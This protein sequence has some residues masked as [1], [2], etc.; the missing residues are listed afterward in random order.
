MERKI[1]FY[2]KLVNPLKDK[3]QKALERDDLV[4]TIV[5]IKG[6]NKRGLIYKTEEVS[7]LVVMDTPMVVEYDDDEE[8]DDDEEKDLDLDLAD[9][10]DD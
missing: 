4:S 6:E 9:D 10:F 5:P 7:Y 8:D 3:F 2:S 1:V